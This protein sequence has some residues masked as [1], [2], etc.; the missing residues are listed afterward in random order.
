MAVTDFTPIAI[1]TRFLPTWYSSASMNAWGKLIDVGA[2]AS[3]LRRWEISFF[4]SGLQPLLRLPLVPLA[5]TLGFQLSAPFYHPPL[6]PSQMPIV[7]STFWNMI[8]NLIWDLIYETKFDSYNRNMSYLFLCP[9]LDHP[10]F[11]PSLRLL[12]A[13]P[14][15]SCTFPDL[16]WDLQLNHN[17]KQTQNCNGPASWKLQ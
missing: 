4:C 17:T 9:P 14:I 6:S 1:K 5:N 3:V 16:V 13:L 12:P 8:L 11:S 2:A 10:L 7:S 15:I